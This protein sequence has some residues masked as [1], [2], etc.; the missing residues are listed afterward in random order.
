[1]LYFLEM[2]ESELRSY[3]GSY[4]PRYSLIFVMFDAGNERSA[5]RWTEIW[6]RFRRYAFPAKEFG[7]GGSSSLDV[8]CFP[9]CL[10][11]IRS[12]IRS[13]L[14]MLRSSA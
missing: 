3:F 13:L 4:R 1:M 8:L 6:V 14:G 2:V 9:A 12:E 7:G 5:R 10:T 11:L